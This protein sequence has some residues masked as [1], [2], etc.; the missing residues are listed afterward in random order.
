[1]G[2]TSRVRAASFGWDKIAAGFS[3]LFN[4]IL[5]KSLKPSS[6]AKVEVESRFS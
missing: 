1:M 5:A 3:D 2:A 4:Q 6:L